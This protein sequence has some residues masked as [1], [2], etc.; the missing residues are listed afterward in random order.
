MLDVTIS[1]LF[2]FDT[3]YI[4]D[5]NVWVIEQLKAALL[6]LRRSEYYLYTIVGESGSGKT[7]VCN[8]L[9]QFAQFRNIPITSINA[10]LLVGERPGIDGAILPP[11]RNGVL[12]I[13][14]AHL[15][16]N[17]QAL[18]KLLF[19]LIEEGNETN[20]PT[21]LF[22]KD[23]QASLGDITSRITSN[24]ILELHAL[25]DS[26][27]ATVIKKRCNYKGLLISDQTVEYMLKHLPRDGKNMQFVLTALDAL[28]LVQGKKTITIPLVKS[29]IYSKKA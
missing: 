17:N 23:W 1:D 12:L 8:S 3:F 10:N 2:S 27:L 5:R 11:A 20:Y 25:S 13:D 28:S 7:H 14:D 9:I 6:D 15:L 16:T 18:E 19:F 21:I 4:E 22:L 24:C 29:L 26:T